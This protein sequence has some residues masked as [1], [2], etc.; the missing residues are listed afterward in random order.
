MPYNLRSLLSSDN[1]P[2]FC[3]PGFETTKWKLDSHNLSDIVDA[4]A[5]KTRIDA[6]PRI[7][8]PMELNPT[9][10]LI[11]LE[12]QAMADWQEV[13]HPAPKNPAGWEQEFWWLTGL[14]Q[15]LF[16][17]RASDGREERRRF[18]VY[19]GA[20]ASPLAFCERDDSGNFFPGQETANIDFFSMSL[21]R[22]T[23]LWL[24]RDYL[25][26]LQ[27]YLPQNTPPD[28]EDDAL[29][30]LSQSVGELLWQDS[31]KGQR[32]YYSDQLGLFKKD[33]QS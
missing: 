4:T 25:T 22:K 23:H 16:P 14:P 19:D 29:K 31:R 32:Y 27:N 7:Q 9:H 15:M 18:Y 33:W 2:V 24:T 28:E 6:I 26:A 5:L 12:H 3:H 1:G 30:K 17:F 21:E 13:K 11:D 8:R 10:R 20:A